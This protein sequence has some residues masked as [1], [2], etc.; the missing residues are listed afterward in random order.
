MNSSD[1]SGNPL[2]YHQPGPDMNVTVHSSPPPMIRVSGS[3]REM[4]R[5]IGE[6]CRDQVQHGIQNTLSLLES[7]YKDLQLTWEGA[8]RSEVYPLC[9][10][11]LS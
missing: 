8:V 11:A 7:A 6:A 4:G 5:Q 9:P 2:S 1:L 10:G 3:H